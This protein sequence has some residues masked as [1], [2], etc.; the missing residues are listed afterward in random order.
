VSVPVLRKPEHHPKGWGNEVWLANNELYCGK[1]LD[2]NRGATCSSH[3]H[4]KKSE[5]QYLLSGEARLWWKNPLNGKDCFMEL[6]AGDVVDI[7]RLC[8]HR[9]EAITAVRILEISSQHFENDS[10]RVSPGDSQK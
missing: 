8:V 10:M 3:F 9:I 5:S 4:D 6:R 1:I 7:P 2:F